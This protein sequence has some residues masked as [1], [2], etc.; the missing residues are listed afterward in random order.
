MEKNSKNINDLA[1]EYM[2]QKYAEK[3]E[4]S[5]PYGNSMAGTREFFITC[6]SLQNQQ[7]LVQIENCFK[8]NKIFR[9][10]YSAVKYKNECIE[11]LQKCAADIFGNATIFYEVA[12]N[13]LSSELPANATFN[14]FLADTRVPLIVM[15]EVSESSFTNEE[16]VS[17][18]GELIAVN[19]TDFIL[20]VVVV[21]DDKYGS[22]NHETLNN[23]IS[24]NLFVKCVQL[25]KIDDNVQID[26][27]REEW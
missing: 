10:N 8:D 6:A 3:F 24:L 9:D 11:F 12:N 27:L 23:Q 14:E 1:I 21:E 13:G 26:W 16:Q 17:K 4:Y 15:I 18:V 2:E 5:K 7:I 19:G 22:F 25:T 20:S